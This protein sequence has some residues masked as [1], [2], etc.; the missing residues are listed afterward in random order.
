MGVYIFKCK[1]ADWI[2]VGNLS[3]TKTR[4]NVYYRIASRGFYSCKHP[5]EL[6][7][8]LSIDDVELVAWYPTLTTKDESEIHKACSASHGE[9]HPVSDLEAVVEHCDSK[10]E[11]VPVSRV[12]RARAIQW[13]STNKA[14]K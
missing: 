7:G 1:G 4:P 8:K 12:E 13:A 10:G 5:V 6:Q 11:S 2:K 14:K 9:F 3:I